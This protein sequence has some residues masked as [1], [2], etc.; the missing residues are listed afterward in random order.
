MD[1]LVLGAGGYLGTALVALLAARGERV[2]AVGRAF[3]E[4][5]GPAGVERLACDLYAL[6]RSDLDALIARAPIIHHLAWSSLPAAAEADVPGDHAGN[7]GF[8]VRLLEAVRRTDGRLIFSSSGGTVYGRGAGAAALTED[9]A[10]R[11]IGAYGAAKAA[12]EVYAG[13]FRDGYGC[14]IRIARL[15]NP[16]GGGQQPGRL[17]GALSRFAAQAV[18][19]EEIEIWGDG[20]VVR[21]YLHVSDAVAGLAALAQVD[22]ARLGDDAVFNIASGRG[23]SLNELVGLLQANLGAPVRVRYREGRRLDV[24]RSVLDVGRARRLLDWAPR[25]SLEQGVMRLLAEISSG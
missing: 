25:L 15:S 1:H 16:Y 18:A 13:L 8:M 4:A 21:D 9:A 2:V 20:S 6:P 24:P 10:L 11:P 7:V 19:G 5:P 22:R 17:Q 14:D 23:A 3:P 12:A